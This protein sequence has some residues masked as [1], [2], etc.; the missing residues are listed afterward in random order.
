[1]AADEKVRFIADCHLGRL[2]KYLRFMGYD[3]LYFPHI[4][5]GVLVSRAQNEHR[6]IL[7][8]D[9][10]LSQRRN[11]PVFRL[12]P[13]ATDAQLRELAQRFSLHILEDDRRRCLV[14]NA[15]LLRIDKAQLPKNVPEKVLDGF[16]VFRQCPSC[17]RIYWNGDHYRNLM[18]YLESVLGEAV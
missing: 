13:E 16:D 11:A 6:I 8:R 10:A 5:D 12:D 4:E 3:T 14:C 2:A 9:V 18:T 1:M 15:P 17:G 7:T